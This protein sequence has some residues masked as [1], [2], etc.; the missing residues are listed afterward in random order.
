[1]DTQSQSAQKIK[2][3]V[4]HVIHEAFGD[5]GVDQSQSAQKKNSVVDSNT[6]RQKESL[7]KLNKLYQDAGKKLVELFIELCPD[8][9][10]AL[11]AGYRL[12]N[13]AWIGTGFYSTELKTPLLQLNMTFT[14]AN[15]DDPNT[16]FQIHH[17]HEAPLNESWQQLVSRTES[18]VNQDLLEGD[19]EQHCPESATKPILQHNTIPVSMKLAEKLG[20]LAAIILQHFYYLLVE[21]YGR[22]ID[23]ERWLYNS[24]WKW[25]DQHFQGLTEWQYRKGRDKLRQLGLLKTCQPRAHEWNQT[26]YHTIDYEKLKA[27]ILSIG[28]QSPIDWR[29]LTNPLVTAHQSIKESK[30]AANLTSSTQSA[31]APPPQ[32]REGSTGVTPCKGDASASSLRANPCMEPP[33]P[34]SENSSHE[35]GMLKPPARVAAKTP[36]VDSECLEA[37]DDHSAA[38]PPKSPGKSYS[39]VQLESLKRLGVLL[40]SAL[41]SQLCKV[42]PKQID[43]AIACFVET[44]QSWSKNKPMK[45]PTGVFTTVLKQVVKVGFKPSHLS[46]PLIKDLQVWKERWFNPVSFNSRPR[47][48]KEIQEAFSLGEIIVRDWDEGPILGDS[49]LSL[50]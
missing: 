46:N 41:L 5:N 7:E 24:R 47:M 14:M 42:T 2:T 33:P 20:L 49:S 30:P 31:A 40:N 27:L 13:I 29:P 6:E 3:V 10:T 11:A 1:M 43:D 15:G 50:D 4:D 16:E 32:P 48:L 9:A 18:R 23:N 17:N 34:C 37:D 35:G 36:L 38:T 26:N 44:K 8:L 45:N 28:E 25:V 39:P 22:D 12:K 19:A 21:G